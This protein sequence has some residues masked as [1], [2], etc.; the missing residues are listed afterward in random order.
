MHRVIVR[1]TGSQRDESGEQDTIRMMA[2]GRHYFR[3]GK[4]YVLYDEK[5][6]TGEKG[7]KTSTVLK[8][9]P[10]SVTLLRQGAVVQRQHFAEGEE[11]KGD[12]QTPYGTLQL[13]FH[14]DKLDIDYGTVAG[15]VDVGFALAV[16]GQHRS[17]NTLHI[18]VTS[19]P[20]DKH[21]LN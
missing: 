10:E 2:E 4:H 8:I 20:E 7:D 19:A 18:E 17:D 16:N 5:D 11:S 13:S 12:Y 3:N 15:T 6:L 14:T 21:K 1:V 9:G